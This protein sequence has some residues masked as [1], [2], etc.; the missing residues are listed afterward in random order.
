MDFATLKTEFYAR[1]FDYLN[2]SGAGTARAGRWVNQAYLE[3]CELGGWPF[4]D[5]TATGAAPLTIA[6]LRTVESVVDTATNTILAHVDRRTATE[7]DPTLPATGPPCI[8]WI[9][10]GTT[11]TTYPT[12]GTLSVRYWKVP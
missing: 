10:G 6:D 4:L 1:G 9:A 2:D 12:G 8:Y 5:A 7:W 3:L 11:I